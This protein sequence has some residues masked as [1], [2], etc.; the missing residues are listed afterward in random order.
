M[1]EQ[2][3]H[4]NII[5]TKKERYIFDDGYIKTTEQNNID[6]ADYFIEDEFVSAFC[7]DCGEY[8]AEQ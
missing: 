2:C 3:L 5:I 7:E 6:M 4:K 1:K 8:F